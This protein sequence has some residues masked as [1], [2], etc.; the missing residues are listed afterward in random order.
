L[1]LLFAAAASFASTT[2]RYLYTAINDASSCYFS[3]IARLLQKEIIA[4]KLQGYLL[5]F[6]R[7]SA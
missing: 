6:F 4:L 2:L 3:S 7:Y 1:L 5:F